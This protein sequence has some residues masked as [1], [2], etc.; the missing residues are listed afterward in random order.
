M[1]A[2]AKYSTKKL[3]LYLLIAFCYGIQYASAQSSAEDNI[4]TKSIS[5]KGI[6]SGVGVY[7][8]FEGR[9]PCR[10]IAKQ[11]QIPIEG[12]C[13]KLKWRLTLYHD[14]VTK[15]PTTYTLEG[16]FFRE[17]EKQGKWMILKGMPANAKAII[18]QLDPDKPQ[19]Y[20][21]FLKGDDNVLFILDENK[22][23][24]VGNLDFSYTLNRV[25]PKE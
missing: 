9:P 16:S 1:N 2:I 13:P 19:D 5:I 6:A 8:V 22:N 4:P 18:I 7:G 10:E 14:P 21:Y 20:F 11:M 17:K 15:A 25:D 24:R 12:D 3:R 23:F